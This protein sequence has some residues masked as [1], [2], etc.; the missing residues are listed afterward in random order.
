MP[1]VQHKKGLRSLNWLNFF[2]ADISTGVG[3]FLAV[4]LTANQHWK[5]AQIGIVLASMSFA[6][7]ITQSFAGY[8]VSRTTRKKVPI[9]AASI[10]MGLLSFSILFFPS[11]A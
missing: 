8:V 1:Q 9:V 6:A 4:F 10:V 5:A 7:V 11:F 3:P 2:A